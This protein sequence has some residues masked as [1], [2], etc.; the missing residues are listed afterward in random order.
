[1]P[2]LLYNLVI[3]T[4]HEC[5]IVEPAIAELALWMKDVYW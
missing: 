4:S 1:M 5:A 2:S 3:A